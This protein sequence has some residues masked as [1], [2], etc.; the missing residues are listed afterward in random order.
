VINYCIPVAFFNEHP[1]KRIGVCI[2]VRQLESQQQHRWRNEISQAPESFYFGFDF[3]SG[4]DTEVG[5]IVTML[6]SRMQN[7]SVGFELRSIWAKRT[8]KKNPFPPDRNIAKR[9]DRQFLQEM[10]S[11]RPLETTHA[12]NTQQNETLNR[13]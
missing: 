13:Y 2:S 1:L 6:Q 8:F 11:A 4:V 3:R 12:T 5:L 10:Y 9:T 7:C